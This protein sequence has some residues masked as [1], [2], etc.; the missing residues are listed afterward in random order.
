MTRDFIE[1][2]G[3]AFVAHRLRRSSDLIV[4]QV[5]EVLATLDVDVPPRGAS[6]MLLIDQEGPIGVVEISRR[7]R[8]SH[9]LIV[10]MVQRFVTAGLATI[11]ADAQDARRRLVVATDKGRKQAAKIRAFNDRLGMALE[12]LFAEIDCPMVEVLDRLDAALE[13]TPIAQRLPRQP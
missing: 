11:D 8:L 12:A 1:S 13:A 4:Q 10:R 5:G 7:L 3:N 6:M 9:P 2:Q